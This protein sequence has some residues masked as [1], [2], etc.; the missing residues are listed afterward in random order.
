[1]TRAARALLSAIPFAVVAVCVL[2]LASLAGCVRVA[3]RSNSGGHHEA[4]RVTPGPVAVGAGSRTACHP[5][6]TDTERAGRQGCGTRAFYFVPTYTEESSWI[7]NRAS[8]ASST[9]TKARLRRSRR[10][11]SSPTCTATTAST[12]P[13]LI[14]AALK[15]A[16]A[17]SFSAKTRL[18]ASAGAGLR[19][20]KGSGAP[21]RPALEAEACGSCMG[22][23][24]SRGDDGGKTPRS[25]ATGIQHSENAGTV[26]RPKLPAYPTRACVGLARVGASRRRDFAGGRETSC[27]LDAAP[28][29]LP[30]DGGK[31]RGRSQAERVTRSRDNRGPIGARSAIAQRT[32]SYTGATGG[33]SAASIGGGSS[34]RGAA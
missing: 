23:R 31:D 34:I 21:A 2:T 29:A 5:V 7:K 10:P 9:S 32:P 28:T 20:S 1:M 11:S 14:A 4:S 16:R 25:C 30:R 12:S 24:A 26:T 33:E 17:A 15:S 22:S 3:P 18:P 8:A 27:T 6:V 13:A 19:A